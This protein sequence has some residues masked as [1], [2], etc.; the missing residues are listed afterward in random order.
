MM[1]PESSTA[2]R[3]AISP[4][5]TTVVDTDAK[6][7]PIFGT[8]AELIAK[9]ESAEISKRAVFDCV[10]QVPEGRKLL[11][12]ARLADAQSVRRHHAE[13]IAAVYANLI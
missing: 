6:W 13:H 7:L 4:L 2:E 10:R 9:L 5:S 8:P 12:A 1:W 3:A 11:Q